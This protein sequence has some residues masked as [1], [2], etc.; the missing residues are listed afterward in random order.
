MLG[1]GI[2]EMGLLLAVAIIVIGPDRL[3]E[4]A[5]TW[6]ATFSRIRRGIDAAR[7]EID[8]VIDAPELPPKPPVESPEASR[9]APRE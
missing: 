4:L 2:A 7:Q 5:R 6:G 8:T 1:I 9:M 3:P